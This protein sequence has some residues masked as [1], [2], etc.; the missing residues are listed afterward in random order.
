MTV[1]WFFDFGNSRRNNM[2]KKMLRVISRNGKVTEYWHI[3]INVLLE[4]LNWNFLN[5]S[6]KVY[7]CNTEIIYFL[8]RHF[9]GNYIVSIWFRIWTFQYAKKKNRC[10]RHEAFGNGEL[11]WAHFMQISAQSIWH[12]I[13]FT[14][15]DQK[16]ALSHSRF[17]VSFH[18]PESSPGHCWTDR[19]RISQKRTAQRSVWR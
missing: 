18:N 3:N 5:S 12:L 19:L 6:D 1:H 9:F 11:N 15:T 4:F 14:L 17:F 8:K 7:V 10:H 16:P 13:A 2:P